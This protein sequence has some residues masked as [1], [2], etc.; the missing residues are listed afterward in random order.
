MLEA[1]GWRTRSRNYELLRLRRRG[2]T[3]RIGSVRRKKPTSH[4]ESQ[5]CSGGEPRYQRGTTT[6]EAPQPCLL[7]EARSHRHRLTRPF[8]TET[9]EI[10]YRTDVHDKNGIG[11]GAQ[12]T[13]D[14]SC[15]RTHTLSK[16]EAT[17][18]VQA[19]TD[20]AS[21]RRGRHRRQWR[22]SVAPGGNSAKKSEQRA[23]EKTP[24][25]ERCRTGDD[26]SSDTS[27]AWPSRAGR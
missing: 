11:S 9:V 5:D 4:C 7:D 1:A 13:F 22:I 19:E 25:A 14:G 16:S 20:L 6:G 10:A 15:S 21:R 27:V 8:V 24:D 2:W 18:I 12:R 23:A 17:L 3:G 26:R